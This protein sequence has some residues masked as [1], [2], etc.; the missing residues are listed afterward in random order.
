[1]KSVHLHGT[2]DLRIHEDPRLVAGDEEKLIRL[3]IVSVCD[4]DLHWFGDE[5]E[6]KRYANSN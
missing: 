1:V 2:G 5:H 6:S 4:S 3:R